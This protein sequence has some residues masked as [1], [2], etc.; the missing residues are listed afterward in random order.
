MLPT[1]LP[2]GE[3]ENDNPTKA[4]KRKRQENQRAM[5]VPSYKPDSKSHRSSE[6]IETICK[7]SPSLIQENGSSNRNPKKAR[8]D[9]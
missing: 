3:Q 7:V 9:L 2:N 5:A 6:E 8:F 4:S 1:L